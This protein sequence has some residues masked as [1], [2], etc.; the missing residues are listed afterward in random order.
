M[1]NVANALIRLK[2]C[3]GSR[4][5][6]VSRYITTGDA[7]RELGI[8]SATLT[9]WAAAG[10]VTP[11]ERTAGGHFRWDMASLRPSC[12]AQPRQQR[13]HR[14]GHRPGR[15]RR[16]PRT[17]DRPGRPGAVP[18]WDEAPD[19]QVREAVAGVREVLRNPGLTAEQSH[20]LWMDRMRAD[21]W[22]YGEVKDPARKTHPTLLPFGELPPEQQ[23]KDRLFIAVSGRWPPQATAVAADPPAGRDRWIRWD[24]ELTSTCPEC[25]RA[26]ADHPGGHPVPGARR[27]PRPGPPPCKGR[28]SRRPGR[29]LNGPPGFSLSRASPTQ[30]PGPAFI[31][32]SVNCTGAP[33]DRSP[34]SR[35]TTSPPEPSP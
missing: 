14:G 32:A 23:L 28:A 15:P 34:R 6:V 19:Y 7:A 21:G 35:R 16:E 20:E 24:Q 22:T 27:A 8:S 1:P 4:V 30:I 3:K 12:A 13:R 2:H 25:G 33:L 29:R 10:T 17:A 9:R 11:A 18:P 31:C 5:P 26:W